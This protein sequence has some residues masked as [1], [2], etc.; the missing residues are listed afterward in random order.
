MIGLSTPVRTGQL[1]TF[2]RSTARKVITLPAGSTR[3]IGEADGPGYLARIWVTFPGWFYAH[4]EPERPVD[5]SMLRSVIL[6][7]TCDGAEHPQIA[8]PIA[9][10]CGVGLGWAANF[11]ARRLGM[12]SGGFYLQFPIPYAEHVRVEVANVH[13]EHETDVFCN[14]LYQTVT[15]LPPGTPQLH[16]VAS[17]GRNAGDQDLVLADLEG[18]GRYVG[19]TVSMQ[20]ERRNN[21]VFLE[22]PEQITIDDDADDAP[23]IVGT[24]TEDYFLGG[25]YFREG[26]FAG[27]DHG[28][29][30][31]HALDSSVAMYRIHEEDAI[32]F[33]QRFRMAFVPTLP[34]ER[35]QPYAWSAVAFCY[36][37]PAGPPVAEPAP[38]ELQWPW[39]RHRD[40]DHQSLP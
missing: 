4:W 9:D 7:I 27:P 11:A 21:L 14:V 17:A 18:R 16:T 2:D 30:I 23:R 38:T 36:L 10:L 26:T 39:Y 20:G 28:V 25:W 37:D 5:Q 8:A 32:H 31:K 22:P 15:E 12:S 29:P 24:G 40:T 6:K 33:D 19:C 34:P 3:T 13:P 1:T 35:L